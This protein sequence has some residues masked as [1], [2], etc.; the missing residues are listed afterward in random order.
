MTVV[1]GLVRKLCAGPI[2]HRDKNTPDDR[3][4]GLGFRLAADA[5]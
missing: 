5:E 2:A 1:F 4:N 3:G